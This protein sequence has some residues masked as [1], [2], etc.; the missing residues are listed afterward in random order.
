MESEAFKLLS[1]LVNEGKLAVTQPKLMWDLLETFS[2]L[3]DDQKTS[4][5]TQL[6]KISGRVLHNSHTILHDSSRYETE[7]GRQN[8]ISV[9]FELLLAEE[10]ADVA[11]RI[12]DL[13]SFLVSNSPV[14]K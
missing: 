7:G 3:S 13:I 8:V 10:S 5:L 6:L 1:S 14:Q 9:L 12:L 11:E 4:I 2:N